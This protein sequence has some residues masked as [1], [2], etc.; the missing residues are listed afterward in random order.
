RK[1]LEVLMESIRNN[2]IL[3]PL[4]V[5]QERTGQFYIM[6]GERRWRCAEL[7][8]TDSANPQ[9]VVIPANVVDRPR[10]VVSILQMFHIHNLRRQWELMPTALSLKIVMEKLQE[11]DDKKLAELTQLSPPHVARCK[12]LLSYSDKYQKLMMASDP[13]KRIKANFFIEL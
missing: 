11:T 5:Y 4:T 1:P 8:E 2:G 9:H 7:I 12:V 6:D 10:P 3:V 13:D